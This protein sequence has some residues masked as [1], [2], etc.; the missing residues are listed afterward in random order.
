MSPRSI[1]D[2][3][4]RMLRN[5]LMRSTAVLAGLLWF[6]SSTWP[7]L[8]EDVTSIYT[9]YSDGEPWPRIID[10]F[11]R[12]LHMSSPDVKL[13][14]VRYNASSPFRLYKAGILRASDR[15]WKE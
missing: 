5:L 7:C 9:C 1:S 13:H 2:S 14:L 6:D 4:S 11:T 3:S 12:S 10:H 15:D 8:A